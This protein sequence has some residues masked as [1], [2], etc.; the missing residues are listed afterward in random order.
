MK[1]VNDYG[2]ANYR[3]TV[4]QVR[5][6][7]IYSHWQC[8]YLTIGWRRR[9]RGYDN[10]TGRRWMCY[11]YTPKNK[12]LKDIVWHPKV[13]IENL[14]TKFTAKARKKDVAKRTKNK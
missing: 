9:K 1:C 7:E 4:H 11:M 5:K 2:V 10:T 3:C 6:S 14:I 8:T 12:P 13:Q